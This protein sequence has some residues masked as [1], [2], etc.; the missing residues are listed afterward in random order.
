[1]FTNK[2]NRKRKIAAQVRNTH[3]LVF[4]LVLVLVTVMAIVMVTDITNGVSKNFAIFIPVK[5]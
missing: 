5:P 3:M 4:I 2:P 1:M